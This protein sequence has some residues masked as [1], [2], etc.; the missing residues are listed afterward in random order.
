MTRKSFRTST[1]AANVEFDVDGEVFHCRNE[2]GAGILMKF[3]D[4]SLDDPDDATRGHQ[5][6]AGIRQFFTA[7]LVPVDRQRFFDLLEDPDRPV[8]INTL[9]DIATW[10]GSEYTARPTGT[11]SST[12][13]SATGNGDASTAG[14]VPGGTTFSRKETPVA[15]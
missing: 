4:M 8:D 14:P 2:I 3:A 5:A 6:L 13:S 11:P 9:I 12:T 10:L 7:A 1:G 15:G